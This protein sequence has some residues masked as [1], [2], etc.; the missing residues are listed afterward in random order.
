MSISYANSLNEV[1]AV[2]KSAQV[3]SENVPAAAAF[4]EEVEP[5]EGVWERDYT[6]EQYIYVDNEGNEIPEYHDDKIST[7]DEEKNIVLGHGQLSLEQEENSQYVQFEMP[8]KYD[9][10]DLS[11]TAITIHYDTSAGKHYN[12]PAVDVMYNRELG[13][14]RYSWLIEGDATQVPGKLILSIHADGVNSKGKAYRWKTKPYDKIVVHE[15]LCTDCDGDIEIDDSWVQKIVDKVGE[16]IAEAN[17][18]TFVTEARKAAEEA[19]ESAINSANAATSA[20]NEALEKGKYTKE[21]DSILVFENPDGDTGYVDREELE[22]TLSGYYTEEET[23]AYIE[24]KLGFGEAD[25]S[26]TVA[27]FVEDKGYL[28]EHQSLENYALKAEIPTNVSAFTNDAGYLTEHQSLENYPTKGELEQAIKGVDVTEQLQDYA[29]KSEL[30]KLDG[31]ATEDFVAEKLG[32]KLGKIVSVTI[33]T[34]EE[35]GETT[36]TET[37]VTV[38]EYVD[39]AVANIDI[40]DRLGKIKD[41]ENN[42]ITVETYVAQ[43]IGKVDVSAQIDAKVGEIDKDTVKEYVDDKVSSVDVSEQLEDYATTEAVNDMFDEKLGEIVSVSEEV[44]AETGETVEVKESITVKEYVDTAVQSVDV[45]DQLIGLAKEEYVEERLGDLGEDTTGEGDEAVTLKKT[46]KK[47]VDDKMTNYATVTALQNINQ[48]VSGHT[49]SIG[50]LSR[51]FSSIKT[52]VDDVKGIPHYTYEASFGDFEDEDGTTQK[53]TF[54]LWQK[55]AEG[56]L[57]VASRFPISGGGGGGASTANKLEIY[58]DKD[59]AGKNINSYVFTN[60]NVAEEKSFIKFEFAGTDPMG[61][62]VP[63][64]NA[65]WATKKK[66]TT[67][68][69]TVFVGAVNEGENTFNIGEYLS[70][71]KYD[72]RI[73]V[74]DDSGAYIQKSWSVQ[75]V[76]FKIESE[77]ND[78]T[79]YVSGDVSISYT[80]YGSIAKDIHIIVDGSESIVSDASSGNP[81]PYVVRGLGHGSHLVEMYMT[82]QFEGNSEPTESN[83]IFKDIICLDASNTTPVIGTVYQEFTARQYDT[84][85]IEY[86][87]YDPLNSE[88]PVVEIF[89]NDQIVSTLTL[90]KPTNIYAFKSDSLE[91]CVIKIKCRDTEKILHATIIPLDIDASPVLTGLEFDF[92]PVGRSN[93]GDNRLWMDANNPAVTLSVSDNFD[94]INGGY[95]RDENKDQYFCVKAGTRATINYKLFENDPKATG[96]EFKVI[97]RSKNARRRNTSFIQCLNDGIGLDMKIEGAFVQC[98]NG[99]LKSNYCEDAIIEYEFNINKAEDMTIVMSYEDGTPSTPF[100]YDATT[101]FKQQTAQPITIGSDDCDIHIYRMKAYSKSLSDSEILKNFIADARNA[102]EMINRHD[103][104]QIFDENNALITTTAAGGFSADALMKAAPDL[105]YVFLEAPKFTA[106]KGE[107][108]TGSTVYFRYP[109]GKRPQDN[110]VC[111]NMVHHGQGTSSNEYGQAGRN[112][113]LVMDG[114]DCEFEWINEAGETVTSSTIT[115]SDNSV[116]TDY[117]NIKVNI[118]SSEN[119]NNAGMAKRFNDYQPFVRYAKLKNEK[120]KDTMEFYNCVVFIRETNEDIISHREFNDTNWHF[121]AI[122]NIGDSKKTDDTR[123]NDKNDVKEHVVEIMDVDVDLAE[124]PTGIAGN[125]I[126]PETSWKEGNAAYEILYSPYKLKDGKFK[127]FGNES[128]EFRYEKKGITEEEREANI[129]AWRKFYKFVVTSSN[130]D[131]Y[132]NLKHYFV[133]DSALYFY[134]FTERYTMVDNRAKNSFWHYGKAYYSHAEA[135]QYGLN[136]TDPRVTKYIDD[137]EAAIDNGYRYDLTFGYDFDTCLGIDNTGNFVFPYGKEDTDYYGESN[138]TPV[139]RANNSVFFCRLRDLFSS[140]MEAMFKDRETAEAWLSES[141]I[142]QWD[143]AQAQFPEELWRLDYQRKYYRTYSGESIDNSVTSGKQNEGFL[144]GKFFGRK[145]YARRAFEMDNEI[146]FASKYFGNKVMLNSGYIRGYLGDDILN[147]T[148]NYSITI[149][150]YSD[151]YLIIRYGSTGDPLHSVYSIKDGV[152][153]NLIGKP[154]RIKAG[155]SYKFVN[156]AKKMDFVSFYGLSRIQE[157][158]DLSRCYMNEGDFSDALHLQR[159][160]IG[161]SEDGYNNTF[162]EKLVIDNTP[163]LEHLDL[164]NISGFNGALDLKDCNNLKELF[165]EGTKISSV[166]FS[167]GGLLETAHLPGTISTLSMKNLSYLKDW[168]VAGYDNIRSLTVESCPA[169]NTYEIV[170]TA[171][172]N[173]TLR[174]LRLIDMNWPASYEIPDDAIFEDILADNNQDGKPDVGG[175]DSSSIETDLASLT[176]KAYVSVIGEKDWDD[177]KTIWPGLEIEYGED[178]PQ[179]EV[180]FVNWEDEVVDTQYVIGGDPAEDPSKKPDVA[181]RLKKPSSKAEDYHFVGWSG[182]LDKIVESK[183]FK[184]IYESSPRTYT[185]QYVSNPTGKHEKVLQTIENVPYGTVACYDEEKYGIPAYTNDE[186]VGKFYLFSHWKES[187]LADGEKEKIEAVFDE[188]NFYDNVNYFYENKIEDLSYVELYAL[189]QLVKQGLVTLEEKEDASGVVVARGAVAVGDPYTLKL[190]YDVDYEDVNSELLIE[191]TTVFDGTA[192]SSIR[193]TNIKLFDEDKDFVLAIDYEFSEGNQDGAVLMQCYDSHNSSGV[194]LGFTN[195]NN[196][197][198]QW[199]AGTP[200]TLASQNEREMLVIRHCKGKSDLEIFKSS[201][202]GDFVTTTPLYKAQGTKINDTLVFGFA[203]IGEQVF[204]GYAK[205]KIHWCKIWW[206]DIGKEECRKLAQWVHEPLNMEI[207]GLD[208]YFL[209]GGNGL[210]SITLISN[211]LLSRKKIWNVD[212]DGNATTAGGWAESYLNSYLNARVYNALPIQLKQIV[213]EVSYP[214]LAGEKSEEVIT[215]T[216]KILIPAVV[217][218]FESCSDVY[219]KEL[220]TRSTNKGMPGM[221]NVSDRIFYYPDGTTGEY[222]LRTPCVTGTYKNRANTVTDTGNMYSNGRTSYSAYGVSII[223][224]L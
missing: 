180:V 170:R 189:C 150:P 219:K 67:A 24:G 92:N 183:R 97:F 220:N 214:C 201:L 55:N 38:K 110:W 83:H 115:L 71:G 12:H 143:D 204:D 78:K 34:D 68:W 154:K 26:K 194:K 36:M 128:Y 54:V 210:S 58:Y 181:I 33:E 48:T 217:D 199:G 20:V 8:L 51:D 209:D 193:D 184:A 103:R 91:S 172:N 149:T 191:H 156:D 163:L 82:A 178:K 188:F 75:L 57:E 40:S 66:G 42:D 84:T 87:V 203:K 30:P 108:I 11:K 197:C 109:A 46:V 169:V 61:D 72:V 186:T 125:E 207:G 15:A 49:D 74:S 114:D 161:S 221:A 89:V 176:G 205:G 148:P 18:D 206:G 146:Y 122:G 35:T 21:E 213:K 127:S 43:E 3:A 135:E 107:D 37:S 119:A 2:A 130:E 218:M 93:E 23:N 137:E 29:L 80:P 124:F 77:F 6:Y 44:D 166:N 1:G 168:Q 25:K 104:N 212:S 151:M 113:D 47:Y 195:E 85:N 152:G 79:S 155:E 133:V 140:E 94:W 98:S 39:T 111:R 52:E 117:L 134:L 164:R 69:T 126:C 216:S 177:Y 50:T 171:L 196:V 102:S 88:N 174:N 53:D 7:V 17:L 139:F 131:F 13:L 95:Q 121:Y 101:S 173:G 60:D 65:V 105:R 182:S 141:L 190:G 59:Q 41:E 200:E 165:A 144:T 223:I 56:E 157:F 147:P 73:A 10:F 116:P 159:L 28:T 64:A 86:T 222:W 138:N 70:A 224:N 90:E 14:I 9:G 106:D 31:Y 132:Q 27:Q 185:I 16:Q 160:V 162:L 142:K 145:K 136:I 76:E 153:E 179:F 129:D 167:N 120:I 100:K 123:V 99:T 198:C 158:N 112:M 211:T 63:S 118:A 22:Q 175:L 19:A 32:E 96:K 4:S 5:N 62:L 202:N 81:V 192:S 187:G 45:K 208:R 215:A